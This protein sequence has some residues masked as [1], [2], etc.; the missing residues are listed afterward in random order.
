MKSRDL[1]QEAL[2]ALLASLGPDRTAAAHVY[3]AL[4]HRLV[5]LFIWERCPEPEL[6]ADET[7][8]RMARRMA[9]G[10]A[11]L[12]PYRYAHRIA[13]MVVLETIRKTQRER[14]ALRELSFAMRQIPALETSLVALRK[15]LG[16]LPAE[17][18]TLIE[19]YYSKDRE[20]LAVAMGISV[21]TLRN[22][23]LRIRERLYACVMR[24]RD[25]S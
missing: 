24:R 7:L 17:S 20:Q 25:E 11:I 21:N 9:E 13:R 3:E 15:C 16:V 8:N 4:R 10:E 12:D 6:L 23:A 18:R 2:D 1:S 14:A 19:Q 5:D 22:R